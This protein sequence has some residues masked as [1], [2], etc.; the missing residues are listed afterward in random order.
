MNFEISSRYLSHLEREIKNDVAAYRQNKAEDGM[1]KRAI[2]AS[3]DYNEFRNFVSVSQ[4]KPTSGRDVSSLFGGASGSLP[5][6]SFGSRK[7]Q[8]GKTAAIGGF[9]D[10]I[11]RRK[12]DVPKNSSTSTSVAKLDGSIHSLVSGD[13]LANKLKSKSNSVKSSR[14]AH[15]FL[16]EWKQCCTSAEATLSF[17]ARLKNADGTSFQ[18]QLLLQPDVI[19]DKYFS[20]DIDSDILGGIVEALHLLSNRKNNIESL[21]LET[22]RLA[23]IRGWIKALPTCGRFELSIS[24]LMQNQRLKLKEICNFLEDSKEEHDKVS[25][26]EY[27]VQYASLL[28]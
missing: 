22:S 5:T 3:S 10:L 27:L 20:A 28:K 21:S 9:D 24:F 11:R 16:R 14:E 25:D 1:K 12:E 2:H 15:D 6:G 7:N 19:C 13:G 26:K 8:G 17:L 4:L 18:N 23:F